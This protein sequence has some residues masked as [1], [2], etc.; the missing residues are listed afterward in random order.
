MKKS[1][2]LSL[3]VLLGGAI[4]PNA[5]PADAADVSF[6][7]RT[8][9]PATGIDGGNDHVLFYEY[10]ALDADNFGTP[11]WYVRAG[12]WGRADLADETYDKKTNGDLQY[13][14]VGWR[15][16]SNNA[17]AR[18]GRISYTGGAARN[19]VFDGALF[20]SD[21]P[22]G[23]DVTLYG[24]VPEETDNEEGRSGDSLY[25]ARVS[26][27]SGAYRIGA[28][29]LKE[30]NDSESA[31]EE[32]GADL[33][34]AP[35]A[36]VEAAGSS[37]YDL[38]GDGWAQHNYRLDVGPFARRVRLAATWVWTDYAHYFQ[39][40]TNEA[41]D[42]VDPEE[43]LSRI[44]A[45]VQVD[46]DR[47]LKLT[48]EY[49]NY[50]YDIAGSSQ[51]FGASLDWAGGGRTAG[52]GYRKVDGDEEENR[53]QEFRVY[54]TSPIGPVAAAAG[55]EH[56]AYDE[57]INGESGATTGSLTVGYNVSRALEVSASA[58]YGVTPDFEHETNFLLAVLWRYDASTK[59][60]GK[61]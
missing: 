2:A 37:L 14:F 19:E 56:L 38:D 27:G 32:A 25:G 55:I 39:G 60:G 48:G 8:Y 36:L 58:E 42:E 18:L 51:S 41:F 13:G 46:L 4:A 24:G 31:R 49:V 6:E 47:G 23:F 3:L 10:L 1:V 29:Y 45:Q 12:G 34:Y 9:V 52:L 5:P 20:G 26:Q 17:E 22:A 53:Y 44:G 16:P 15:G 57:D 61:P 28:S 11:G 33:F 35:T 21:L 59:K 43:Q 50:S 40:T 7:S 30:E 54:A